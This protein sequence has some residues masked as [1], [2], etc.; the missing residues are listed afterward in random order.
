M[1]TVAPAGAEEDT[2][3]PMVRH[4]VLYILE[5]F[6]TLK[7]YF[8]SQ[9]TF[10]ALKVLHASSLGINISQNFHCVLS[11]SDLVGQFDETSSHP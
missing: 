8:S 2:A 4:F 9:V 10:A 11:I 3:L 6:R 7:A 5:L 1:S